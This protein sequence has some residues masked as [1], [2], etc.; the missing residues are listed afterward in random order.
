MSFSRLEQ[1]SSENESNEATRNLVL[2]VASLSF[3]G[4]TELKQSTNSSSST[5]YELDSF[6]KPQPE[7]KGSTVRNLQAFQLLQSVFMKSESV[8][9]SSTILDAISTIYTADNVNYFIL[10][11]QNTLSQFADRIWK[12][13]RKAQEKFF[14][15]IEFL[16]H[17]LK[18]V[19][20]KELIAMT[21][22]L[23]AQKNLDCCVLAVQSLQSILRFDEIFKNVFREV[24]MV[25]V[26]VTLLQSYADYLKSFVVAKSESQPRPQMLHLGESVIGILGELLGGGQAGNENAS[27]FRKLGGPT[28]VLAL[29]KVE[30]SRDAA[31]GLMQQLVLSGSEEDMTALLDLLHTSSSL[32]VTKPNL[33]MKAEVL[34]VVI[35]CLRESHRIRA[36]FRWVIYVTRFLFYFF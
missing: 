10:E 20:C 7:N 18:F 2:L 5:L 8:Q 31:L 32:K 24:G 13:P 6:I 4:H 3:C 33:D 1:T 22:L 36:V 11:N 25:E 12:K 30:E 21:L 27:V 35:A 19:P 26:F 16:V 23:K 9:L 17:H 34:H 28:T 14:Q 29:I 15:L